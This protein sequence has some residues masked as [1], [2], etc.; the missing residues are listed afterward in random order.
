MQELQLISIGGIMLGGTTKPFMITAINENEIVSQYIVKAF[1]KNQ[2]FQ[3]SSVSKEIIC[4]ELAKMFDLNTPNYGIINFNS[5]DLLGIYDREHISNLH[6]GAKFCSE[7]MG[8]Y[9]IF[10]PLTSYS[11]LSDYEIANI[12]A[13]DIL[14]SNVD[15]GGFRNK[16]NLLINDKNLMLI[17]HELTFPYI[18]DEDYEKRLALYQYK[19]HT[20][21]SNIIKLKN[22][23]HCF[24]EF[25]Y[26]LSTLNINKID[27]IF[28]ELNKYEIKF[29]DRL[30]FMN[31]FAWAKNNVT[32]FENYLNAVI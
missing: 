10:S 11:F 26:S 12:F 23:K 7:F 27:N 22:K 30:N 9:T 16:P 6:T 4:S 20:L 15:R 18:G 17:D 13:F 19:K 29:N 28:N 8:Q 25:L 32:I 21:Y 2:V 24:D 3:N 1:T 31:Y 5:L 14:I